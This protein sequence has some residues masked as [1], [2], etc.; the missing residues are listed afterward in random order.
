[1][2]Y[3][4]LIGW[5]K[6]EL[7]YYGS[8]YAES[9]VPEDLWKTYFTSSKNVKNLRLTLGEPDIIQVRKTFLTAEDARRWEINVIRRMKIVQSK[10][11][12]NQRNPGG[13][14]DFIRKKGSTP[15][16]KGLMGSQVSAFK[17]MS[18]TEEVKQ[19]LSKKNK[20]YFIE[21]TDEYRLRYLKRDSCNNR[22]WVN[23]NG[24]HKRV[25]LENLQTF[26]DEGYIE[27]RIQIRNKNGKFAGANI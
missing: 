8:R 13:L 12:L 4:Y 20:R 1:M 21:N 9:C 3:T 16:N 23:K 17:G 11:W 27:G 24:L 22:R 6:E 19:T 2:A 26:I 10:H 18:H 14:G 15:W 7:Y 5:S 25:K